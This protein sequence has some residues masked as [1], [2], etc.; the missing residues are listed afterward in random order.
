MNIRRFILI[1]LVIL[2]VGVAVGFY[3]WNKPPENQST[4]TPDFEED[5]TP[6]V[7]QLN[8]D[9]AAT[10]NFSNF[11]GKSVKFTG[12]VSD[13]LGDDRLTLQIKTGVEGFSLNANF[14]P[15]FQSAVDAVVA[16]D[17]VVLQCI[18]DGLTVPA[19]S[20]DLFSEKKIDMSRCALLKLE[21]HQADVSKSVDHP[22]TQT[23]ADGP[24]AK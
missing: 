6:W 8:A 20:D 12:E 16:G 15:D 4:G 13:V 3:L 17:K 10:Q 22:E 19:S 7:E 21:Q 2:M 24:V 18:C 11:V 9:T 5:L 14:H 23:E 1:L